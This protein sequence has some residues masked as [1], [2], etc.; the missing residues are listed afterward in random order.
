MHHPDAPAWPVKS[1]VWSGLCRAMTKDDK[2][3]S[4]SL[5]SSW[6]CSWVAARFLRSQPSGSWAERKV[7]TGLSGGGQGQTSGRLLY[8]PL[9]PLLLPSCWGP[10]SREPGSTQRGVAGLESMVLVHLGLQTGALTQPGLWN[11]RDP[12]WLVSGAS[13]LPLGSHLV[14]LLLLR[15]QVHFSD[16]SGY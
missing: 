1:R 7:R 5:R 10:N 6:W 16:D 8:R 13:N 11:W 3:S 12:T 9:V 2:A 4:E 15:V 14:V